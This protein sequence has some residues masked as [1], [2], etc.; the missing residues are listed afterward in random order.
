MPQEQVLAASFY[1]KFFAR[2]LNLHLLKRR[3]EE[4]KE[5]QS[6]S[7]IN[8]KEP[9]SAQAPVFVPPSQEK[10][11]S[12]AISEHDYPPKK[13][14]RKRTVPEDEIDTLFSAALGNKVKSGAAS[15]SILVREKASPTDREMQDVMQAIRGVPHESSH[16]KKRRK[17]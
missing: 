6:N 8:A 9:E 15:R 10:Q 4:W 3:P 17:T 14:S 11:Q 5:L 2:N 12:S 7:K 16:S 1:G 13:S